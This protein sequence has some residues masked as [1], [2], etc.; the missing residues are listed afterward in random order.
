M[1]SKV[2]I[3]N[4][5]LRGL[6]AVSIASVTEDTENA[7]RMNGVYD[8][9]LEAM[10]RIHPWS[11]AK[12]ES[13]LSLVVGTPTLT[14]YTYI[15]SLPADF[16][17]LTKTDAEPTY[18]HKIKGRNLYSNATNL[19][20]E[21]IYLCTDT[22]IFDSAFVDAFAARLAAEMAYAITRDK[23]VTKIKWE[24]FNMKL[25]TARS[26]NAQEITPDT[27]QADDWLNARL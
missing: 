11:F 3:I 16:L 13:A 4:M 26:M 6:G 20:I 10:L 7:R 19:K 21:Y 27:A 8:Q 12:K 23:E 1:S 2:E 18:S 22:T 25:R 15:Y 24:E 14:E 5:A 17:K 9:Y